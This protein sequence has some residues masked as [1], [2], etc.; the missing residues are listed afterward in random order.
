MFGK[1]SESGKIVEVKLL[2]VECA[3]SDGTY[4]IDQQEQCQEHK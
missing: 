1:Y 3:I 2:S 4:D